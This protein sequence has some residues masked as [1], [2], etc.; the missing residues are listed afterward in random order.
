MV[1]IQ[2]GEFY[3]Y[4]LELEKKG[5]EEKKDSFSRS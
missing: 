4:F 1:K 5:E 3:F 2:L